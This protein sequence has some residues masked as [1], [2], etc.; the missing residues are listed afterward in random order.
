M[1]TIPAK[2]VLRLREALYSQ[3][4]DVAEELASADR[5]PGREVHDEWSEAVA[6]FDRARALLDEIG[7]TE[8]DPER[9][10][11]IDLDRHRQVIVA[12]LSDQ[13]EAERYLMADKGRAAE[14]QRQRAYGRALIIE[15][16][17][18]SVGLELDRE[19]T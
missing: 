18:E 10:A 16:F 15:C 19:E 8:S 1:I 3:L 14:S 4:G 9:D 5:R 12:A 7:W 13:L 6:R 2:A 17:A 11:E